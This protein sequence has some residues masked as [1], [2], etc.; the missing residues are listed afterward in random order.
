[1]HTTGAPA[2]QNACDTSEN[3]WRAGQYKS[4]GPV[5]P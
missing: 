2:G 4:D 3:E 1:M 5:K